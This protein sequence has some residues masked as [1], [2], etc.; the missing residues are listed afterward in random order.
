MNVYR[1]GSQKTR[2]HKVVHLTNMWYISSLQKL[3]NCVR[4]YQNFI[5]FSL[6]IFSSVSCQHLFSVPYVRTGITFG[7]YE[8]MK[9]LGFCKTF[10]FINVLHIFVPVWFLQRIKNCMQCHLQPLGVQ[11]LNDSFEENLFNSRETSLINNLW[12]VSLTKLS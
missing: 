1:M 6:I 11:N 10:F 8:S 5:Q 9:G 7:S 2:E 4:K 3:C 12:S